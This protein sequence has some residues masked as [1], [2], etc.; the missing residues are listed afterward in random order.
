MCSSESP[1]QRMAMNDV[2]PK[3]TDI[4]KVYSAAMKGLG[5]TI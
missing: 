4:K 2:V 1:E 3:L 5:I